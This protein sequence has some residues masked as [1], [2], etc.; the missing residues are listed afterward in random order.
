MS[1]TSIKDTT[2]LSSNLQYIKTQ[3]RASAEALF[4]IARLRHPT[5]MY[6]AVVLYR[7][8]D[9]GSA[10]KPRQIMLP[11]SISTILSLDLFSRI[12][13]QMEIKV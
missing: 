4:R 2:P 13:D 5:W 10:V 12:V 9:R 8:P 11:D 6:V 1:V 7:R 3:R